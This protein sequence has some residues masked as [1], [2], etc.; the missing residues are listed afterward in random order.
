[1]TN[2]AN[3]KIRTLCMM[4]LAALW[5]S[6]AAVVTAQ[7]ACT[8]PSGTVTRQTYSSGLLGQTMY[9]TIYMPPC[10]DADYNTTYPTLY[11]MHGSNEDDGHWVRL[12]IVDLLDAGI[13]SGDLPP[14]LVVLPFGNVI[15]NRN[16]F[17]A[18]S[19]GNIFM[20]EL[21]PTVE[22]LYRTDD[23]RAIGGI[24]RGGFWAYQ[25]ALKHPDLFPIVGGHSAFFDLY[26]APEEENPLHL[27]ESVDLTNMRFWLDRG[28]DDFAYEGL[29][30]MGERL[31][32]QQADYQY[33]IQPEGQHNNAYW[34]QYVADYLAFYVADW[35]DA[36]PS[37]PQPT[38]PP[39]SA[40][41]T[42]TP[43]S[44]LAA[45]AQPTP[46]ATALSTTKTGQSTWNAFFPV[47]AFPSLRTSISS[48]WVAQVANGEAVPD[49]IL[50]TDTLAQMQATGLTISSDVQTVAP[51]ALRNALWR[52]YNAIT[53]L[54]I[55]RIGVD[56]RILW[57][58]DVPIVDQLE[59]YALALPAS[60]G[61]FDP[62][63]LYRLTLSGVTALTR[64][65]TTALDDNGIE[66]AASGIQ[67]Y[68]QRSDAFHI[69]NEVSIY[70]TCPQTTE[71]TLGGPTS[72]CSKPE[73][74]GLLPLLDVDIVELSGNHN[75][76]YGYQVYTDTYAYY[77]SHGMATVG[78]GLT[79]EE[80][81]RPLL[82]DDGAVAMLTCN[83]PG[84]YYA[85][86]N[87]DASLLGG[88]RPGAAACDWDWL[89]QV[90]PELSQQAGTVIV[91]LQHFEIED[92]VP[93]DEQRIDFRRLAD[94]GA[95]VVIS[96]AAHKPQTFEFYTT[97][98]GERALLHY[99]LGNLF[100]DQPFWGNSRFF[101]DTLYIYESRLVGVELFP[102]LI[103]DL[104]R[105]R[106]MTPDER[107]QFLFFMLRQQNGF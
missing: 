48:D 18:L 81:R 44:P 39:A 51:D 91:T 92:Y 37:Q 93:S 104:A 32:A 70:P 72:F 38:S 33:T 13:T 42:N 27:V 68:V 99:G 74:F 16:R 80:A 26:H 15:A 69:S 58:D 49:L 82:L 53:L 84:P 102:G 103:E 88:L 90:L 96:T 17:D 61:N 29:D 75:N 63:A 100:F 65:T 52:D 6:L 89:S 12:G 19:W 59:S 62:S 55:D 106:L 3:S 47:V 4:I 54:P 66:W 1:M 94:L 107:E 73:H 8:E 50:D 9:Y 101:M 57:L 95:D 41:A 34:S 97:Q 77:Q 21:L 28:K 46:E 60:N 40:F 2:L 85:L 71:P 25:I 64:Q 31:A 11:L 7:P 36:Q 23:R 22:D 45:T 105:P 86:V 67:D 98:S 30:I 43:S 56:M 87:E 76:D 79:L 24:S 14:M 20:T 10:Y 5:L 78:G 83:I 35:L